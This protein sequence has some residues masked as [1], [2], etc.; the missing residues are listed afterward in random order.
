MST[1]R[2]VADRVVMLHPAT[3]LEEREPQVIFEGSAAEAFASGDLR[4][5]Q[6]VKGEAGERLREL[7]IAG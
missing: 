3:R 7:A 6:F 4:V 1:V 2:K 5:S